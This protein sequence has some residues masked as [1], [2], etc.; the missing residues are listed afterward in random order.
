VETK[1]VSE[2]PARLR[3]RVNVSIRHAVGLSQDPPPR[4]D[5]SAESYFA[6][7]SVARV[8]HGDLSS[9]LVGGLGSL[10]FQML[11]PHAMAGVAQHSRYQRDALGRLLQTANFIGYTTYGSKATAYHSI[12]RVLAVHEGVRGVA[13]DGVAYYANDPHLLAWVHAAEVSMFLRAYQRYG[14]LS[15]TDREADQYVNEMA[16][17]A[18]DMGITDP[19]TNMA[20]L[21][22]VI[23]R[24]RAELRLS[25]DAVIARDF[26]AKGVVKGPHQKL[27]YWL[28]VQSS[29]DLMAPW[30]RQ[31]LG[32]PSRG[33]LDRL[34]VRPATA[35]LCSLLRLFVPPTPRVS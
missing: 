6:L 29:Y 4:C 18:R 30:A 28:L 26:V 25:A 14:R 34:V 22:S 5:D 9:M 3:K 33:W 24:F 8:V 31:M 27:A 7:D 10:F 21:E 2:A 1:W 11:H 35:G 19:P 17:L 15:I 13:D 23:L 20:Q 32:V 16:T 12:E